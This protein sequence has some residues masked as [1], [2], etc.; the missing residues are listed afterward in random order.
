MGNYSSP[1]TR[2]HVMANFSPDG[3]FRDVT[4][5]SSGSLSDAVSMEYAQARG[6]A[7]VV[8]SEWTAANIG[9]QVSM[10]DSTYYKL[11]DKSGSRVKISGVG[12]ATAGVYMAPSEAWCMGVWKYMKI[13][14]I[15]TSDGTAEAQGAERVL[16]VTLL[17]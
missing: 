11:F 16:S 2:G 17:A 6:V 8:P 12:T 10:D 1:T 3:S 14:S 7:V 15:D 13:E 9:F 4:I 5:A